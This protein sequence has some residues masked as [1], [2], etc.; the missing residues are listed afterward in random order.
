MSLASGDFVKNHPENVKFL[1]AVHFLDYLD[2][3]E[4]N[5]RG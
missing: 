2:F 3:S 1:A 4:G 5:I